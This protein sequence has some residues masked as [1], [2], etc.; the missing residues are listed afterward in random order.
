MDSKR[1]PIRLLAVCLAICLLPVI[2]LF[3]GVDWSVASLP[4]KDPVLES[5][6][7]T[8][9][10]GAVIAVSHAKSSR[11]K[12]LI[13]AANLT[14]IDLTIPDQPVWTD[15]D[16]RSFRSPENS[17]IGKGSALAW[18]GHL[19]AL[20]WFLSTPLSTA[21]ILEDDVDWSIHLRRT[22]IPLAAAAL[23]ALLSPNTTSTYWGPLTWE[24]LHLGHCGDFLASPY[25]NPSLAPY[26]ANAP[27][28][29]Y[30]TY[31]DPTLPPRSRLR[32]QTAEFLGALPEQTRLLHPSRWPLCTFGYAVTRASA[33]RLLETYGTEGPG[34][35]QAYDVRILEACR[36]HGWGCWSVNPELLHHVEGGSE[37]AG[38]DA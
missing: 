2:Y 13:F 28:H 32:P 7:S 6:N 21:I 33:A 9:G 20:K 34:G 17:R 25:D 38:V 27:S 5:A 19:Y 16:L 37:I 1:K 26:L 24:L 18:M 35:C 22:Q 30:S 36:D 23:R 11:R 3:F 12:D 14:G 10:F 31:H 15:R 4:R 8:L 29:T